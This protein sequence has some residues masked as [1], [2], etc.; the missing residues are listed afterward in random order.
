MNNVKTEED[1]T[2]K[3]LEEF[4]RSDR[5]YP[6]NHLFYDNNVEFF[7]RTL[8]LAPDL[9]R[10][11]RMRMRKVSSPSLSS[12]P[13]FSSSVVPSMLLVFFL[14][15]ILFLQV[16]MRVYIPPLELPPVVD[17]RLKLLVLSLAS[18]S[19]LPPLMP[20]SVICSLALV[21]TKSQGL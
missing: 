20:N 17:K 16:V 11:E 2:G 8:P 19:L 9:T 14:T 12:P 3:K 1:L 21:T 7:I 4:M 13:S 15:F 5:W 6:V 10:A 18:A